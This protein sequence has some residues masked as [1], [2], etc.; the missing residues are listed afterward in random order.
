MECVYK[1]LQSLNYTNV[2]NTVM[3]SKITEWRQ[4]Y[5]GHLND[6]HDYTIKNGKNSISMK[7]HKL[8]SVKKICETWGNLLLNE[9]CL[10]TV[11]D[12]ETNR[13]IKELFNS[14][15]IEI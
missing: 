10:I 8:N 12:D 11:D 9:K 1:Y 6:F 7:M 4:W 5:A 13:F 2:Q 14:N 15:N 3:Q